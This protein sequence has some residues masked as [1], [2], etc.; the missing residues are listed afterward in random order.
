MNSAS[1]NS[2]VALVRQR[3]NLVNMA[4]IDDTT[5]QEFTYSSLSDLYELIVSRWKDYYITGPYYISLSP[6]QTSYPLPLDFRAMNQVFLTFGQTP[7]QRRKP[8]RRFNWNEYQTFLSS[9]FAAPQWPIMYR[10]VGKNVLFTPVSS[11]AYPN[12]IEFWYTPQYTPPTNV[13][14]TIDPVLPN[15]WERYVEFD[16]CVQIASRMRLPEFYQ[17]YSQERARVEARVM[18]AANVRDEESEVMTDIH[19]NSGLDFTF[20]TPGTGGP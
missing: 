7:N 18:A 14:D 16:V 4:N 19:E 13:N 20:G 15:G 12:A 5:I 6:T 3:M 10:C 2:I 11:Q 9:G 8:L 1:I 17:M